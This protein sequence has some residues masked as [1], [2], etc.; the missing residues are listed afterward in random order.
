MLIEFIMP[1]D[2]LF[3]KLNVLLIILLVVGLA[4]IHVR[5]IK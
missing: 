1:E 4:C 2:K 3:D 5:V